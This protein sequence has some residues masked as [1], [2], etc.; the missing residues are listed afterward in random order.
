MVK[1]AHYLGRFFFLRNVVGYIR[2]F[3]RKHYMQINNI[4]MLVKYNDDHLKVDNFRNNRR[5]EIA[6]L[7]SLAC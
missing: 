1:L 2:I 7:I 3:E 6:S 4:L 5:K